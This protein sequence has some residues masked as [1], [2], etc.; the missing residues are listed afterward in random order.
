[1]LI[2]GSFKTS[3]QKIGECDL[4]KAQKIVDDAYEY[5]AEHG[6]YVP[7]PCGVM[8]L[9][10]SPRWE[11]YIEGIFIIGLDDQ[12]IIIIV[13]VPCGGCETAWGDG[14]GFPGK[15]WGMYFAY[16]VV[17]DCIIDPPPVYESSPKGKKK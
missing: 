10:L 5:R 4:I 15:N 3:D 12:K 6:F 1:M 8:A 16:D 7:P 13:P 17:N 14:A 2:S 11:L 9:I